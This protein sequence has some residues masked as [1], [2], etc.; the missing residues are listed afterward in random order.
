MRGIAPVWNLLAYGFFVWASREINP[1]H[2]DVGFVA[3]K[4]SE[5]EVKLGIRP[6]QRYFRF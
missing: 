1:H 4:R 5:Y 3:R 2:A 6:G